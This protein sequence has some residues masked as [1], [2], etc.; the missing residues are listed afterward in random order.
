MTEPYLIN[1]LFSDLMSSDKAGARRVKV[2]SQGSEIAASYEERLYS[3]AASYEVAAGQSVGLNIS[4]ASRIII[5]NITTNN[6]FPVELYSDHATGSADGIFR[7]A[8]MNMCS[9]DESPTSGQVFYN[10]QASGSRLAFGHGHLSTSVICCEDSK[11]CVFITNTSLE[12]TTIDIQVQ[13]EEVGE[14]SALF[15]LTASTQLEPNTE[16]SQY[17]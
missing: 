3:I 1:G 16:M 13:F 10:A 17:G 6:N 9:I 7:S 12:T 14:R 2:S 15:G 5:S 11:P 4:P 8:S